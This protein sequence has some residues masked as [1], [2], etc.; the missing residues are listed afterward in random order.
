MALLLFM[1]VVRA[2]TFFLQ[3]LLSLFSRKHEFEADAYA[4]QHADPP[5]SRR[6]WSSSTRTTPPP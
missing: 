5:S 3:P 1:L 4:A 6:R 2:F